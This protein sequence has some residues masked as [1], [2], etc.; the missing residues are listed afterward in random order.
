MMV[1]KTAGVLKLKSY[2]FKR[3][4]KVGIAV[5]MASKNTNL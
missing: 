1:P 2:G 3:I 5:M 4:S